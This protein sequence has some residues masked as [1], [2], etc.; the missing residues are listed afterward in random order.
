VGRSLLI[1]VSRI[2]SDTRHTVGLLWTSDRPFA[3]TSTCQHTALT[4][5][6]HPWPRRDSNPQSQ[7]ASDRKPSR[8]RG[9]WHQPINLLIYGNQYRCPKS[10]SS[11]PGTG[12]TNLYSLFVNTFAVKFFVSPSLFLLSSSLIFNRP[13]FLPT[14]DDVDISALRFTTCTPTPQQFKLAVYFST[15]YRRGVQFHTPRLLSILR[16]RACERG[17]MRKLRLQYD[18]LS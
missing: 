11:V 9:H 3:E 5:D 14:S 1:E 10:R 6:R 4:K 16:A 13:F 12:K 8:P 2:H 7:Q 17:R 15:M 18:K